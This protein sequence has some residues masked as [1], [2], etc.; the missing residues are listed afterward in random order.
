[1]KGKR[2]SRALAI[3][4]VI[5]LFAV[6][7]PAQEI[8]AKIKI[9][10]VSTPSARVEGRFLVRNNN[11]NWTFLRSIA[12]AEN[13]S[14]RISDLVLKNKSGNVVS[15]K[16]LI[17]GEYLTED[18]ATDFSYQVDLSPPKKLSS[19]AHVSWISENKG[20]LMLGDLLPQF[21]WQFGGHVS[22]NI[23]LELPEGWTT[24]AIPQ[25]LEKKSFRVGGLENAILLVGKNLRKSGVMIGEMRRDGTWSRRGELSIS[26][27][28][29][30]LFSDD[31]AAQAAEELIYEYEKIFGEIP[32]RYAQIFL[33][34]F[35]PDTRLGNWEAE[36]RG[37]NIV[38]LSSDMPFKNQSVQRLHEQFRHELFHLWIPNNLA[39]T[40][41]YDWFYEGFALYQSLRTGVNLNRIRFEDF[42]DTLARAYDLDSLQS[43][44][45]SLIEAS[46]N[47][48]S[49]ANAQI[50]A[51]GMLV[52]FL[53]DVALLRASKGK[54]SISDVLRDIYRKH[55]KPNKPED[56]NLSILNILESRAELRA[57][58][59]RY[60]KG[61][62]KIDWRADL[63]AIGIETNGEIFPAK[64]AVKS[65]LTT[66]QKDLLNDLGYNNWRKLSQKSK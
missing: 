63:E 51:R 49:G 59:G 3:L 33:I 19:M 16:E 14:E 8:E 41:N 35:P 55:Q 11:K 15:Y 32:D 39:L 34:K 21:E 28:D 52:A 64:L 60:I 4:A 48:W 38:I 54:R 43:R 29:E 12:G 23:K 27:L 44:K 24:S 65:K 26:V 47:R 25:S 50:Y 42:L 46:K 31:E 17:P 66:R 2:F 13:L 9:E 22:A 62:E 6:F 61:A 53:S 10:S 57:V 40:G 20:L 56:G 36:T 45:V 30:W 58:V 7:C 37:S 1:M 18:F 5:F